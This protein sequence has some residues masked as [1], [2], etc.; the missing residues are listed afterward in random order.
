MK[1]DWKD[2]KDEIEKEIDAI[3]VNEPIEVTLTRKGI[4]PGRAGAYHDTYFGN[5]FFQVSET[6]GLGPYIMEPLFCQA[7]A[8]DSFTVE[9]IKKM[10]VFTYYRKCKLLGDEEGDK[11]PAAWFNMPKAWK[12]YN[13]IVES[14]DSIT[15]MK[16]MK[17]L[18]WSWFAYL[19]RMYRWWALIFPWESSGPLMHCISSVEDAEEILKYTK[20][21]TKVLHADV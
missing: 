16:D 5:L 19:S 13:H 21:A 2:V 11:C 10:F 8:D 17:D 14:F 18:M 15:N 3:W 9:H 6:Q 7:M 12:F 4:V 20:L 1:R